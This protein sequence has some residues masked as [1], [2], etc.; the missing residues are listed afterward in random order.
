MLAAV[1]AAGCKP[2]PQ[3]E[4]T[5]DTSLLS[6]ASLG[7]QQNDVISVFNGVEIPNAMYKC[8]EV[9]GDKAVFAFV[10]NGYSGSPSSVEMGTAPYL[11]AYPF[12]EKY[13]ADKV[14]ATI[15]FD[16]PSNRKWK[17]NSTS[18]EDNMLFGAVEDGVIYMMPVFGVLRLSL[19]GNVT[20]TSIAVSG[21]KPMSGPAVVSLST[22]YPRIS[23]AEGSKMSVNVSLDVE[24]TE[25]R[26]TNVDIVLPEDRYGTLNIVAS[27]TEGNSYVLTMENVS[28]TAGKTLSRARS[29]TQAKKVYEPWPETGMESKTYITNGTIQVGVD[30]ARGGCIFHFSDAANKVNVLNH[31]DNG[32]FVQQ[33]FYGD[34]DGS[35]WVNTA[36]RYNPVQ[37]GGYL[38]AYPARIE[39]S[40]VK[41]DSLACTSIPYHWASCVELDEC[42]MKEVI[43]LEGNVAHMHYTFTYNGET[44]HASR[45]Q[46]MPAV[47]CNW[48]YS[49]LY[50]Y[51]GA[52]PW[53]N[54]DLSHLTPA[55]LE[56]DGNQYLQ[57]NA[58]AEKWAAYMNAEGYGIGVYSPSTTLATY[59]RTGS[60]PSG[61]TKASCSYFAPLGVF[62][63]TPSMTKT[64]DVYMTVGTVSEIRSR[65]QA[66][67]AKQ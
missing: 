14:I 38:N 8:T 7:W 28:I 12:S 37:G 52:Y 49:E 42:R 45:H 33:S 32:R 54:K 9:S 20:L 39:S 47:F 6:A 23:M 2:D 29:I 57:K 24:L 27:D 63:L 44:S 22:G 10:E 66:I 46:E 16:I 3:P 19:T 48:E 65:F 50:Y 4:P 43:T 51:D 53:E 62:G 25:E 60:G 30:M 40:E 41:P 67:H 56:T 5:A 11:A 35:K 64:Y 21:S 18:R 55:K 26:A 59:Y 17:G 61:P 1:A 15:S 58:W 34:A 31:F 13:V 36:W